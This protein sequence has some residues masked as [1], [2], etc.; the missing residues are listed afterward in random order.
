MKVRWGPQQDLA[1]LLIMASIAT[2]YE[3]VFDLVAVWAYPHQPNYSTLEE[4]AHKL[5]LL[6]DR[7]ADWAYTFVWLNKAL[8]HAPLSSKGHI[9]AMTESAPSGEACSCL[10][11][12]QVCKLLQH[13]DLVVCPE[14][15]N[16][17][18]EALQFTF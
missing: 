13:K 7:S 12:L 6:E 1:F 9:S 14:G 3:R 18:M 4:A 17:E 10:H 8:S 11:Q 15:L 2:R 5:V 16:S